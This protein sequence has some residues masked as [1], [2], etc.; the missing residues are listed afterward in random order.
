MRSDNQQRGPR[1]LARGLG[2]FTLTVAVAGL[3]GCGSNVGGSDI[4][5][6]LRQYAV[7]C[8]TSYVDASCQHDANCQF[9]LY[10]E[11]LILTQ[12]Q[13]VLRSIAANTCQADQCAGLQ[14]VEGVIAQTEPLGPAATAFVN[15][16]I[17]KASACGGIP[18]PSTPGLPSVPALPASQV[19]NA[20]PL[21]QDSVFVNMDVCA[22][23]SCQDYLSCIESVLEQNVGP[24]CTSVTFLGSP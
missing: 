22:S 8:N 4:C 23:A 11:E 15:S 20:S 17:D 14:T 7:L 9:L 18:Y 13:C 21:Y 6:A 2:A 1:W 24:G 19:C 5:A 16:C 10:K 12:H 3:S